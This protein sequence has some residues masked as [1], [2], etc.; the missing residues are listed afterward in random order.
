M[1]LGHHCTVVPFCVPENAGSCLRNENRLQSDLSCSRP[2]I[3]G[4][5]LQDGQFI[6]SVVQCDD[7]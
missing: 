1:T 2:F 7:L 4:A 6:Q 5:F 3:E